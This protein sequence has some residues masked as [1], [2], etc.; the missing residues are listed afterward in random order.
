MRTTGAFWKAGVTVSPTLKVSVTDEGLPKS[1]STVALA[2]R[3]NYKTLT[4]DATQ[5]VQLSQLG[6]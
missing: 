6:V 3:V 1:A 5:T 4:T 2:S